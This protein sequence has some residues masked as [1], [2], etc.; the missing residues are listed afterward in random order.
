MCAGTVV[1]MTWKIC[2]ISCNTTVATV[3]ANALNQPGGYRSC[4]AGF[5]FHEGK[6]DVQVLNSEPTFLSPCNSLY[7]PG[8]IICMFNQ[9]TPLQFLLSLHVSVIIGPSSGDVHML[10]L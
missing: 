6:S 3:L 8:S 7:E 5:R 2:S 4:S 1:H 10:K 9:S